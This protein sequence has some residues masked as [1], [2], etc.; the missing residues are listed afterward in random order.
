MNVRRIRQQWGQLRDERRRGAILVL[1]AAMLVLIFAMAAFSLDVGWISL[2]KA[3]MQNAVDAAALSAAMELNPQGD[4]GDVEVNA[5]QAAEDIAALHKAGDTTMVNIAGN[6]GNVEFGRRSFDVSTG[7]YNYEWGPS[8]RPYNVVRVTAKR[9]KFEE[10]GVVTEDNRLPLFFG[11]VIGHPKSELEASAIATFQPR[12]IMLVLDYSSSMNDD[13]QLRA[14]DVFGTT[15]I[16]DEIHG[17]WQDLNQVTYGDLGFEPD[18]VTVP[19]TEFDAEVTWRTDKVDITSTGPMQEVKLYF[20]DGGSK[21]F[22][23]P[24][25]GG[26]FKGTGSQSGDRI[27]DV[28]IK[29][30][31]KTEFVDFY[32]NSHIKRG[33]GLDTVTYPYPHGSWDEFINYCR[34]HSSSMPNYEKAVFDAGYRRQFGM[35]LLI[36]YWNTDRP[37]GYQTPDLWKVRAQPVTGMK[38]AVDV[39]MD[40][41]VEAQ[42]EDQVGF[43]AYTAPSS[44]E[45]VL[46]S[47]LTTDYAAIKTMSRQRQAGHYQHNTNIGAGLQKAR[48]ELETNAR[49]KAYRT[50]VLL[51][52]GL[53]NLTSTGESPKDFVRAE[54]DL[55]A[56][57]NIKVIT[58]SL[59]AGADT[60]LMQ[61]VADATGGIHYNV[62]G[63]TKISDVADQ[64][65]NVFGIIAADRPLKLIEQ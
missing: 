6:T 5:R 61:E 10:S 51:T 34:N 40:Y 8:A 29:R 27:T 44:T 33:L 60:S 38:N 59:G 46:E 39:L 20:S 16:R 50:I 43:V 28:R 64:V 2:T 53:A 22:N 45:A 42:S 3:Q 57:S 18:W 24:G 35:L 26:E 41:L 32:N 31:D 56:D 21:T 7:D 37:L 49:P 54:A 23:S 13:T 48:L 65:R 17:M 63:G 62:P 19:F 12:D 25:S 9:K 30:N 4:Q 36:D 11:P 14:Q 15:A 52:D 55:C 1:T 47:S 58:I